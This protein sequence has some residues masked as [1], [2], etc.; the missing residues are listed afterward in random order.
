VKWRF[1]WF[2]DDQ[3][4]AITENGEYHVHMSPIETEGGTKLVF[5]PGESVGVVYC[6]EYR[7]GKIGVNNIEKTEL[8]NDPHDPDL[9]K[10]GEQARWEH[11][12][13]G[14]DA[15]DG[16]L[17][18]KINMNVTNPTAGHTK[19]VDVL[20][21]SRDNDE[22]YDKTYS[23]TL[24]KSILGP[25]SG[26]YSYDDASFG[27]S[28]NV[29]P[30]SLGNVIVTKRTPVEAE[31]RLII[32]AAEFIDTTTIQFTTNQDLRGV[33]PSNFRITKDGVPT[34]GGGNWSAFGITALTPAFVR[35]SFTH[36]P[37]TM[38]DVLGTSDSV[39]TLE[40][41]EGAI[42]GTLYNALPSASAIIAPRKADIGVVALSDVTFESPTSI[43][44]T[45]DKDLS[46]LNVA[47]PEG[48]GRRGPAPAGAVT[49]IKVIKPDG[50]ALKPEQ[51]P[52]AS[53]NKRQMQLTVTLAEGV[54]ADL[55]EAEGA[56]IEVAE[57]ISSYTTRAWPANP[58]NGKW[59][60]SVEFNK[61]AGPV[62]INV[63]A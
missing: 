35:L 2:R 51:I 48:G 40:I 41:I 13:Y 22:G 15:H 6:L 16:I 8:S 56:T 42:K 24:T 50:T 37:F 14:T 27:L 12:G 58:E 61:G 57:V 63:K 55:K 53:F 28:V 4:I 46:G 59:N 45:V 44:A 47:P 3:I 11:R 49:K 1:G 26:R 7:G 39:I 62:A 43:T 18:Y 17:M 54:F 9:T 5:I 10:F 21:R 31:R 52:S 25:A 38:E 30:D 33:H 60:H 29:N 36:S 19:V 23:L 20:S 32:T 34:T